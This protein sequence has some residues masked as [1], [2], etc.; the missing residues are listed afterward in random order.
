ML[1][2]QVHHIGASLFLDILVLSH[3]RSAAQPQ[4]W[5][6]KTTAAAEAW[7]DVA[8]YFLMHRAR[9]ASSTALPLPGV[10]RK[11]AIKIV[12]NAIRGSGTTGHNRTAHL[13]FVIHN[14]VGTAAIGGVCIRHERSPT[15]SSFDC[16]TSRLSVRT[17]WCAAWP[18]RMAA[19]SPTSQRGYS[20]RAELAS[21]HLTLPSFS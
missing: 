7:C 5:S 15:Q 17:I 18:V 4:V 9:A 2:H 3:T 21:S 1:C 8:Y 13:T 20:L 19:M 16:S 14:V 10:P 6:R 11:A 12:S